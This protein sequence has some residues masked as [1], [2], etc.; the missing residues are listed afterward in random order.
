MPQSPADLL[1]AFIKDPSFPCVGAKSARGKGQLEIYI[2]RDIESAWDDLEVQDRLMKFAWGYKQ[3]PKLFVSFAVIFAGSKP[4]SEEQFEVALW[5]RIQ[6]LSDKDE[7]RGQRPDERVSH[8]PDD[9]HFSLSFGGEAFFVV[10]LHP[11]AS[12]PAR[13][14]QHPTMIFNLHDQFELL[15]EQNRYQPLKSAILDRDR[16]LAGSINPMLAEFGTISEAR[17]YS[18]R[19]VPEDWSCPYER[20]QADADDRVKTLDNGRGGS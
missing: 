8:D 6:S 1:S 10:G 3:Q 20:K 16:K 2:A 15:R 13:R 12:R 19:E 4:I 7:W 11:N 9:P 5:D 17:Q 18:G 14:F